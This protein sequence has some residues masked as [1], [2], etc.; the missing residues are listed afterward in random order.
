MKDKKPILWSDAELAACVDA[1]LLMQEKSESG[2]A[3]LKRDV[4]KSLASDTRNETA[5][6]RR[7]QNI[8]SLMK[9]LCLPV[10][11]G[12][13]PAS[14][15]GSGVK[16][17]MLAILQSRGAFFPENYSHTF[18][19]DTLKQK[20]E[21]I[22]RIDLTTHPVGI[23]TPATTLSSKTIYKRDPLTRAWVL[24]NSGGYCEGCD[25]QAPFLTVEGF[26]FLEIHHVCHLAAGG[27]DRT[28]NTLALC[29][30]CHR[31]CH[32]S[33]DSHKFTEYLYGKINRLTRES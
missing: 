29:P 23:K 4:H 27:S 25:Q 10:V 8:S 31:R 22:I 14:N 18:D 30:N 33:L 15:L 20:S 11:T 21:K 1:Y 6:E 2:V 17:R 16:A 3:F 9:E 19:E 13:A 12:Y 7:M 24:K 5:I 32:I 28:S 26:P